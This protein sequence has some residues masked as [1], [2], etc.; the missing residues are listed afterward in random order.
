MFYLV[1]YDVVED[2]P[3]NKIFKFLKDFGYSLQ[4]SV[5]VVDCENRECAKKIFEGVY[6]FI[7]KSTDHVFMVPMCNGCFEKRIVSGEY[8]RFEQAVWIF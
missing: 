5:F 7:D 8:P 1:S 2:K 3:R 4:K 6:E